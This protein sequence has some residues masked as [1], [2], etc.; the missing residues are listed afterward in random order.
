MRVLLEAET[1]LTRNQI[2][3][4]LMG[5]ET[6]EMEELEYDQL[7]CFGIGENNDEDEW[8]NILDKCLQEGFLKEKSVKHGTLTITPAGKK[9]N[10]KPHEVIVNDEEDFNGS[11]VGGLDD[12]LSGALME[13]MNQAMQ[14][15]SERTRRQIK[16]IKA[17][18]RKIALDD[19]AQS[20]NIDLDEVLNDLEDLRKHGKKMDIRYFINEIISKEDI[21]EFRDSIEGPFVMEDVEEEWGDVYNTQELRLLHYLLF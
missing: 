10:K 9:F 15:T 13:S 11:E 8:P 21:E 5:K 3:C 19:F 12:V 18:D 20:E 17:I 6:Q 16:L 2:Q 14:N 7:E 4:I 1:P